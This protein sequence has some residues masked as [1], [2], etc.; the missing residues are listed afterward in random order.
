[1]RWNV[2]RRIVHP[3]LPPEGSNVDGCESQA[4]DRFS[5]LQASYR[6][7]LAVAS[8]LRFRASA[9]STAFV[10]AYRCGT[11]PDSH[12]I[13][14]SITGVRLTRRGDTPQSQ[15]VVA[16]IRSCDK[17]ACMDAT[18]NT[19]QLICE[20]CGAAFGCSPGPGSNCWCREVLL[21][22]KDLKEVRAKYGD[23]L[24]PECLR[25]FVD[26]VPAS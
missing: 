20:S 12:R 1:M 10:P 9:S 14:F 17:K 25:R 4:I 19:R 21:S 18:D 16:R 3:A 11:V 13:P 8:Q 23:C 2:L 15:S 6:F 5:D 24:C 7:L 22:E 26:R